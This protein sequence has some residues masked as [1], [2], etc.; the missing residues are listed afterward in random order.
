MRFCTLR[1]SAGSVIRDHSLFGGVARQWPFFIAA[2]ETEEV[3]TQCDMMCGFACDQTAAERE[4]FIGLQNAQ[5]SD[6][7]ISS[8]PKLERNSR[9][10][11]KGCRQAQVATRTSSVT[12]TATELYCNRPLIRR[13]AFQR[14][15][16]VQNSTDRSRRYKSTKIVGGRVR[17][18]STYHTGCS[19]TTWGQEQPLVF[20]NIFATPT[21][22]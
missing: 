6:D 5:R 2:C 14:S 20:R 9:G 8:S 13:H 1:R 16:L 12:P 4:R 18:K 17:Q 7:Y 11:L 19:E 3:Q 15:D 22:R 21:W 10:C